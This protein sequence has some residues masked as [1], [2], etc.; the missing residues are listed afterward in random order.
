MTYYH[1]INHHHGLIVCFS[2]K[3]A[4]TTLRH[5]FKHSLPEDEI[6]KWRHLSDHMVWPGEIDRYPDYSRILFI[7]DPFRRLVSF[8]CRW[9][10]RNDSDWCFADDE[11]NHRLRGKS[12]SQFLHILEGLAGQALTFQHHLKPQMQ[13]VE[14]VAFDLVIAIEQLNAQLTKIN[15][16]LGIEYA[17][18]TRNATPYDEALREFVYDATPKSLARNGI[19]GCRYFYNPDLVSK[20][21]RLYRDDLECYRAFHDDIALF[22]RHV[23]DHEHA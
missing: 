5:W 19:P 9:V 3:C 20:V 22:K 2:P 23:S 16:A 21:E 10:V 18:N 6:K 13:N 15:E 1:V 4:C 11:K 12:F 7:R 14:R 8:Y 17:V